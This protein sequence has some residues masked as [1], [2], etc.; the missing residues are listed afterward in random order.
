MHNSRKISA[1]IVVGGQ[2]GSEAKG[3]VAAILAAHQENLPGH[4]V[5]IRVGGPNAGHTVYDSN[6]VKYPFRHLPVAAVVN[7]TQL[8]IGPGSEINLEVLAEEIGWLEDNG[9]RWKQRVFVHPQATILLP[10]H[11]EA[12]TEMRGRVGSTA[13]GIGAARAE[14]LWRRAPTA[15]D[16]ADQLWDMGCTVMGGDVE[17]VPEGRHLIEGTQGYGLGLHAGHYPFCTAGD[18]RNVDFLAQSGLP[19]GVQTTTWV[20]FR[21][22]PIRVA[23]NSGPMFEEQTWDEMSRFSDGYIQPERTTVTKLTRRI[24]RWDRYLAR[25]AMAANGF[26]HAQ[27]VRPVLMFVDYLDPGL[28]GETSLAA[29]HR[30]P[31]WPTI[32]EMEEDIGTEFALFG[33]G[34]HSHVW[35]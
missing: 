35:A 11:I 18:C 9:H 28:A 6:G 8:A 29:I 32:R 25:D 15:A 24:G 5:N 31:A 7:D 17:W 13:K 30:S 14:R 22:F 23:G 10:E 1:D 20:V 19:L 26:G 12:E 21:T 16:M 3:H 2:F 27:P 4:S 33:T 34:P